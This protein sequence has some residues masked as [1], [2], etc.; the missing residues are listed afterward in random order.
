[1]MRLYAIL[2]IQQSRCK[3]IDIDLDKEDIIIEREALAGSHALLLRL[4]LSR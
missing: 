3:S 4:S 2:R 1:M